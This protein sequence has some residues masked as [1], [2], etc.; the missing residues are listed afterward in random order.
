MGIVAPS[1]LCVECQ[2]GV[3]PANEYPVLALITTTTEKKFATK[4]NECANQNDKM[5]WQM[6]R[7]M[8]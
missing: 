7:E 2:R 3:Q 4:L 6:R 8:E 5:K 1:K